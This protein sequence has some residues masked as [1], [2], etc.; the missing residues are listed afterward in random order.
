MHEIRRLRMNNIMQK[1]KLDDE[2]E[3]I[4]KIR[5][6]GFEIRLKK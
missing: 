2:E 3:Q 4:E 5:N 1:K 6:S